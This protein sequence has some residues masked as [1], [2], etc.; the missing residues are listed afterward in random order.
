M[1][2]PEMIRLTL[3]NDISYLPIAQ[4]CVRELSR[5]FGFPEE[6]LDQIDLGVEET[7]A[8]VVQHAFEVDEAATFDIICQK[9]PLGLE[10]VIKDKG[11]PF[12]PR[13]VPD[14]RPAASEGDDASG[15]GLF[16]ARQAMDKV[17]FNN[18]GPEGK[19]T[20][21]VKYLPKKNIE[22][23]L[24]ES[25]RMQ[26]EPVPT[27]PAVIQEKIP[28]DVRELRPAEAIQVSRCAYKSH[29]YTFFDDHIYYPDRLIELCDSGQMISAVAVTKENT[30]MGHAA[31]VYPCLAARIAELT[32][33]FVNVEYRGQGC[34]NRLTEYLFT[35]PKRY[36]LD[37]IYA[38]AVTN[39]VFTQKVLVKF[40]FGD[41]G[42]LLATS[43]ATWMFKGIEDS[44]QRISVILSYEY[45]NPP[46]PLPLYAP[47]HHREM[48]AK[49]YANLG[50]SHCFMDP[51]D[52]AAAPSGESVLETEVNMAESCGEIHV[53]KCG[54]QAVR[55]V[56][57]ILRDLCLKQ[58]A[59]VNLFLNLQDPATYFLT[60]KFEEL[61]FFFAGILPKA[62][63]GEALILQY[64]NNVALDYAK[65]H[66]Y[67]D[68]AKELLGYVRD[69]DPNV[70]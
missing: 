27:E 30:F 22:D 58:V 35:V 33:L 16:L 28:Y 13:Q 44:T 49:L 37:G 55:E 7:V 69:R 48:I 47:V 45:T 36:P 65:I 51:P 57:A 56:R 29:G 5:K 64:L 53:K 38:Y 60:R 34:G 18:L 19:E 39:H 15:L 24:S 59:A 1:P 6:E 17:S 46:E 54:E 4:L 70:I 40:K 9:I 31:L 63:V 50:A 23:Y 43:P 61:G 2:K 14:F 41:C 3:P 66:A 11:L 67:T 26:T 8:N 20:R 62:G 12:D 25:E 42:L 52:A 21:L 68:I 10:I 32:F